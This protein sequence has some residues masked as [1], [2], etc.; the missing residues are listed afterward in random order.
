ME[1]G[2]IMV[3]REF[4]AKSVDEAITQ[5][6]LELGVTSDRLD[7]DV[8]QEAASGFLGIGS[9]PAI[10]RARA[11][12]EE[13]LNEEKKAIEA[14]EKASQE[15]VVTKALEKEKE[16]ITS[17]EIEK[18]A[19]AAAAKAKAEGRPEVELR[20]EKRPRN[21]KKNS[22]SRKGAHTKSFHEEEEIVIPE[23]EPS[24]PKP[25]RVVKP[26]SEEKAEE[27]KQTGEDF[28]KSVFGAMQINAEIHTEYD[29]QEGSL[30]C[31]FDGEEM[32]LLIG[33]RGQ[34]LDSLQ[35]LT[36][37]VVNRKS[38]D[39]VRV[40][41][42]TED[43]RARRA[44]TLNNLARNIAYKVK[45]THRPVSLEPMNPYERRI[46]HSSLQGNRFVETYSEGEEPYR[47]VVVTPKRGQ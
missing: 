1:V 46:I 25:E 32:G 33:K 34:T 21:E 11:R 27:L 37:L 3:Y 17:D 9:K 18:R 35:Y 29:Q 42:D 15:S 47:H 10:I 24:K 28:L 19:A 30:S 8:V 38:E 7:Y 45:K 16:I 5:A 4:T 13:E 40:K 41:L 39:Y 12:S 43:Y 6:C 22:R 20:P 23:Y 44:D 2:K 14:A 26:I 36:S 31:T